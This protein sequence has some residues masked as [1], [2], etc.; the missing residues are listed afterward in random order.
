MRVR[1][2]ASAQQTRP[3]IYDD[4]PFDT[5]APAERSSLL[6][7]GE[8]FLKPSQGLVHHLI[9]RQAE[10]N[11]S[12]PAVQYEDE[13]PVTYQELNARAN[14]V[15]RQLVCGRG[16]CVTVCMSRSVAMVIS[17]L[18]VMKT[19]AAYVLLS[20]DSPIERNKAIV[21]KVHAPFTITDQA[22]RSLFP[23]AVVIEDLLFASGQ[24]D[25][26]NLDI[27]QDPSDIAYII[28]TSVSQY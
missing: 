22:T 6:R 24:Y 23:Q 8:A 28:F 9:E 15:A 7:Y 13:A 19:G 2:E 5:M 3:I 4:E 12:A 17:I 21:D 16:T 10:Q 14:A 18:A 11:A 27:Y 25:T 1:L 20:E 26:E